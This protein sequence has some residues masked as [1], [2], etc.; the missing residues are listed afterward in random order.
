[1]LGL[2]DAILVTADSVNMVSEALATGKPVHVIEL[3]GRPGKFGD[4]HRSL[5]ERGLTRPFRGRIESWTYVPPAETERAAREV[6]S[7]LERH[8]KARPAEAD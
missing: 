7:R 2:A 6:L 3:P 5:F 8:R 4:F 1:M